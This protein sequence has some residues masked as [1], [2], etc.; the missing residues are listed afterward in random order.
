[1]SDL[2]TAPVLVY[3]LPDQ[4]RS[5]AMGLNILD[6][7]GALVATVTE[8]ITEEQRGHR[9]HWGSGERSRRTMLVAAPNGVPYFWFDRL[10]V[11][12][13]TTTGGRTLVVA[14]DGTPIGHLDRHTK[15]FDLFDAS[16]RQIG[17]YDYAR[18]FDWQGTEVA[19]SLKDRTGGYFQQLAQGMA[20]GDRHV[21][22]MHYQLPEPLRTLVLC[23]PIAFDVSM[24]S[25]NRPYGHGGYFDNFFS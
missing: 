5:V 11:D 18:I 13:A 24:S 4:G 9:R 7:E 10:H 8:Q 20:R 16:E 22:T 3:D 25:S 21:L 17:H 14:P 6:Q 23:C 12:G 15:G 19:V 2:F 1:M